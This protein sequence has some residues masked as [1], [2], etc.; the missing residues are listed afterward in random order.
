MIAI[1]FFYRKDS[2]IVQSASIATLVRLRFLAD[3]TDTED[4]LCE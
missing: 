4:I 2:N 3:L 1:P